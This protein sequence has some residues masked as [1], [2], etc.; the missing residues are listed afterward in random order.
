MGRFWCRWYL[1]SQVALCRTSR[2]GNYFYNT[3]LGILFTCASNFAILT[4]GLASKGGEYVTST[5]ALWG[6]LRLYDCKEPHARVRVSIFRP[7]I[8]DCRWDCA[9]DRTA[10]FA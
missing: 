5:C 8:R 3:N 9:V 2:I 6:A 1:V 10:W 7:F 4:R